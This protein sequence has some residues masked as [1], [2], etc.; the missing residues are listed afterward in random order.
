[1]SPLVADPDP[2]VRLTL[3]R[4]IDQ[5]VGLGARDLLETALEDDDTRIRDAARQALDRFA[6][7]EG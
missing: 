5:L 2:D 4:H 1:V 6:G 7:T 3:V